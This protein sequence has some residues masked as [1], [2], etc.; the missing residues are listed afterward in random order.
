MQ[1]YANLSH[2][3]KRLASLQRRLDELR[4]EAPF[5]A[6]SAPVTARTRNVRARLGRAQI[7]RLVASYRAGIPTT[8]LMADFG[9]SKTAVLALLRSVGVELR[10]QALTPDQVEGARGLYESGAALAGIEHQL[11]LPRESVRLALIA[12]G[13]QMRARGGR[14]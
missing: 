6:D 4:R 14:Y 12:A 10:R 9:L 13:V 11:G 2:P 5:P 3:S 8:Q 7:E 1:R